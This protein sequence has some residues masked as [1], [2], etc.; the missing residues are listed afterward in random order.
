MNPTEEVKEQ[1]IGEWA[2]DLLACQLEKYVDR[3][4]HLQQLADDLRKAD[5]TNREEL[6]NR[7]VSEIKM[8]WDLFGIGGQS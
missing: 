1:T 2:R 5:E 6:C 3:A 4:I 7:A 8:C